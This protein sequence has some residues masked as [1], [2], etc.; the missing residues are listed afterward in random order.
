MCN[1]TSGTTTAGNVGIDHTNPSAKLEVNG[2]VQCSDLIF[3]FNGAPTTLSS[4][5][6]S[7]TTS[8]I[9]DRWQYHVGKLRR[10]II[11]GYRQRSPEH[12]HFG[13]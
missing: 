5:L 2:N 8:V 7:T 10:R 12:D 3:E 9:G 6:P 1:T 13:G 4:A 11:C